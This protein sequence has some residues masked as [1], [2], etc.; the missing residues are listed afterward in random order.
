MNAQR[1]K[2]TAMFRVSMNAQ[3]GKETTIFRG[4]HECAEGEGDCNVDM[5]CGPQLIC[6]SK[7]CLR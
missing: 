5:D 7:N 6:G 2:E 1:G 3:R 4:V